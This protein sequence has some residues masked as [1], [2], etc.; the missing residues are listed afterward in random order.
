MNKLCISFAL[1]A[2]LFS[3]AGWGF[4]GVWQ[5]KSVHYGFVNTER[6]LNGFSESKKAV[7]KIE[8]EQKKWET[9]RLVIEDSLKAFEKRMESAYAGLSIEQKNAMKK[10]QFQRIEELDHFNQA[11]AKSIEMR[12]VEE[13]QGIYQKI[14]VAME[15]FAHEKKL[16][17]VFAS[18]N[19]NIVY[20][21]GS[22]VDLTDEFVRF[23]NDRFK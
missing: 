11:R 8:E 15:D 17:I 10:E 1:A 19:G 23:L 13:L 6:L 16:D 5:Y 9:Q 22:S 20:G 12:R 18:S 2:I 4:M 3:L 14:N 21:N 7:E